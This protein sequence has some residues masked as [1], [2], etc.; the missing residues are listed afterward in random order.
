[1]SNDEAKNKQKKKKVSKLH[2]RATAN[3]HG[4]Y[5]VCIC[6][7]SLRKIQEGKKKSKFFHTEIEEMTRHQSRCHYR[8]RRRR[9]DEEDVEIYTL[10]H[11]PRITSTSI[12]VYTP[13][14]YNGMRERQSRRVN[15]AARVW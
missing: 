4:L 7:Q 11:K 10:G 5:K 3:I 8:R 15:A 14:V 1:M 12:V 13:Q 9:D 2:T 6:V